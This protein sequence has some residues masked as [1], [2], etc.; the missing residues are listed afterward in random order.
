MLKLLRQFSFT[1]ND[2]ENLLNGNYE[3]SSRPRRVSN[4]V[5]R[6]TENDR[7]NSKQ[8]TTDNENEEENVPRQ[9]LDD[10]IETI[11]PICQDEIKQSHALTWCRKGC[12]NNIHAKCMKMFAQYKISNCDTIS[13]PLCREEWGPLTVL[14][15]DCKGKASLKK[16]CAVVRCQ[17]CTL[18]VR[19]P[20][21]RCIECSQNSYHNKNK[22]NSDI[23]QNTP[24][25]D[26]DAQ[27]SKPMDFCR[28][29]FES[30][31]REHTK[32]HFV[33]SEAVCGS[34]SD[35]IWMPAK[36]PRA[37]PHTLDAATLLS[38]QS[39]ELTN[40]DYDMLL[41]LDRI[42]GSYLP[43]HL[44]E[45]FPAYL[46]QTQELSLGQTSSSA[47]ISYRNDISCCWCRAALTMENKGRQLLCTHIC[48]D[49]CLNERI[50]DAVI[51]GHWKLTSIRCDFESCPF[52]VV[53]PALSRSK[54]KKQGGDST[55]GASADN[56]IK[57][58]ANQLAVGVRIPGQQEQRGSL[59]LPLGIAGKGIQNYSHVN[60]NNTLTNPGGMI[61]EGI[62]TGAGATSRVAGPIGELGNYRFGIPRRPPRIR[63]RSTTFVQNTQGHE[64][65][66]NEANTSLILVGGRTSQP[67]PAAIRQQP[68]EDH[69]QAYPD[70]SSHPTA[71]S[72]SNDKTSLTRNRPPNG[73]IIPQNNDN[74]SGSNSHA[75]GRISNRNA[76]HVRGSRS[77]PAP[78]HRVP[79]ITITGDQ[80]AQLVV[81]SSLSQAPGPSP[82][83]SPFPAPV[84]H[85]SVQRVASLTRLHRHLAEGSAGDDLPVGNV[86]L[87]LTVNNYGSELNA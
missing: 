47:N 49:T 33:Q 19:G 69:Q 35:Y 17:S 22:K 64:E 62:S 3:N 87:C 77:A 79:D 38:L 40:E 67:S 50:T 85:H 82:I 16:S 1:D 36:N 83:P 57:S 80:S 21:F 6:R 12:G 4:H 14:Q 81:R 56:S 48:H 55:T 60:N 25:D 26:E 76:R 75:V 63:A 66:R 73:M 34:I 8:T 41:G 44:I 53:F 7:N 15:E 10:E 61:P 51:E 30:I 46:I 54:K 24:I 43:T 11:C 9:P 27:L 74:G 18:P 84:I 20:F 68:V 2:I 86:P 78:R 13:C 45:S 37:T 23:S 70:A 65:G 28:R 58:D 71:N 31:N 72:L 29:C 5:S 39:R 42:D 32:H 59:A 52:P